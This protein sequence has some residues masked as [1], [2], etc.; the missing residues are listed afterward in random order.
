MPCSVH[1][2]VNRLL[3]SD[4]S[5]LAISMLFV[6]CRGREPIEMSY[7]FR[8]QNNS[9]NSTWNCNFVNMI[10]R[11]PI[12]TPTNFLKPIKDIQQHTVQQHTVY[13]RYSTAYCRPILCQILV[14]HRSGMARLRD[15]EQE[16]QCTSNRKL[17]EQFKGTVSRYCACTKL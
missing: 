17:I 4:I 14:Y 1:F 6:S 11:N 3:P 9:R 10:L 7:L 8:S 2:V 13:Q 5:R 12:C 15:T 16:V